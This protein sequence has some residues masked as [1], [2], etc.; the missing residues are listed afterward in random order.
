MAL[1]ILLLLGVFVVYIISKV[2]ES[3]NT[4]FPPFESDK[5]FW[6]YHVQ[7]SGI[8]DPAERRAFERRK[9]NEM[10]ARERAKNGYKR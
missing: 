8:S 6:D 1:G 10:I 4:P 2:E 9:K 3:M 5:E 7:L